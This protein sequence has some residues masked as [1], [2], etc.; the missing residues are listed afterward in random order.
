MIA[1]RCHS[2]DAAGRRDEGNCGNDFLHRTHTNLSRH[3][4]KRKQNQ[5]PLFSRLH[6]CRF[7]K[8]KREFSSSD[9]QAMFWVELGGKFVVV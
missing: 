5:P 6:F 8:G 2:K 3:L 4:T 9:P 7:E 1:D